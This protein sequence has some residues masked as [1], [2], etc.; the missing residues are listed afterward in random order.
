MVSSS[1]TFSHPKLEWI[2]KLSL[3]EFWKAVST[4][5]KFAVVLLF[6]TFHSFPFSMELLGSMIPTSHRAN[7]KYLNTGNCLWFLNSK[8]C[9]TMQASSHR[10]CGREKNP[11]FQLGNCSVFLI[12]ANVIPL[13]FTY[14]KPL[15]IYSNQHIFLL[16]TVG[17][18]LLC[19][20]KYSISF[21]VF[22]SLPLSH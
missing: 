19:C 7:I 14:E 16:H 10:N 5:N 4:R 22:S 21:F 13:Y 11:K 18:L 15:N 12:L 17:H 8:N 20:I 3:Q 9:A 6:Y 1:F 2:H